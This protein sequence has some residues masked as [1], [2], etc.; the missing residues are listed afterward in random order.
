MRKSIAAATALGIG[1]GSLY[2]LKRERRAQKRA[3]RTGEP[4]HTESSGRDVAGRNDSHAVDDQGTDQAEAADILRNIRDSAFDASNEKLALALG[5][6]I[7]EIETWT[8]GTGVVDG[9]AVMKA[10]QLAF[11]RGVE[12]P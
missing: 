1:A 3:N 12:I 6:P 11:Q 9:D 8:A 4:K 10:R 2:L 5:R 7:E